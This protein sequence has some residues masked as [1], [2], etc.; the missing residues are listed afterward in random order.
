VAG[1]S[2]CPLTTWNPVLA[3][4]LRPSYA[5]PFLKTDLKA[6]NRKVCPFRFGTLRTINFRAFPTPRRALATASR[7]AAPL[8]LRLPTVPLAAQTAF[9]CGSGVPMPPLAFLQA[10]IGLLVLLKAVSGGTT[11]QPS[12][13]VFGQAKVPRVSPI[14]QLDLSHWFLAASQN[15][16]AVQLSGSHAL[17]VGLGTK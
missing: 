7:L 17:R 5:T 6:S 14:G 4:P 1:L 16:L 15:W 13:Q 2:A 11:R 10:K 12:G 8:Q 3:T 9:H